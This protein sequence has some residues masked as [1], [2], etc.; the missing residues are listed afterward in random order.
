MIALEVQ[1]PERIFRRLQ[2]LLDQQPGESI[3]T[4]FAR[5]VALYLLQ[6]G[7]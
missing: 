3:D 1:I 7:K 4:L 6:G 2:T 5:A